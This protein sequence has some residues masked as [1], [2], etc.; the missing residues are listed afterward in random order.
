MDTAFAIERGVHGRQA[1]ELRNLAQRGV[2]RLVSDPA[3]A[4]LGPGQRLLLMS[5]VAFDLS[6]M[7]IWSALL[8]GATVVVAP[9][10]R[11]GL[12]D[13]ASLLRTT[14]V[15]VVWLTAG[16]FHQVAETDI[17]ALA[18]VPVLMSGGDVLNPDAVRAVLAARRGRPFVAG[19]GPAENTTFTS[20]HVMTDP[21]QVAATVPIG[22]PIQ[23]T[24]VR[25]LDAR[26]LPVPIGVTGELCT[27]GDGLA[28]G[29]A[30]DAAATARAAVSRPFYSLDT[31]W[32]AGVSWD[33][34]D[35]ID[36][37]Y[38]A[39][40][41][42]AQYRHR[43]KIAEAYAGWSPG[44]VH[45]LAQRFSAGVAMQDDTYAVEPGDVAA[46]LRTHPGVQESVVLV[47]GEGEQ[48]HLIGYVTPADGVDPTALRP[49]MLHDFA[50]QRLPDYLV[51][52]AFKA[53][54]RFPLTAN[55]KVDRAALPPP[56]SQARG[57]AA[58]PR[59]ATEER[60]AEI[61]RLLL[62]QHSSRDIGRDD[63]FFALG[64]N[65][66]SAARLM[67][68][69]GEV[70]GVDLGLAAFYEAPTLAACAA[71]IDAARPAAQAA[72]GA[73]APAVAPPSTGRTDREAAPRQP[74][75]R[76]PVSAP[77][78]A[79]GR[80]AAPAPHPAQDRPATLGPHLVRL[81]DDW[82]LWRAVCLRGAGFGVHLLEALGDAELARAADAVIAA[83]AAADREAREAAGAGYA[84]EF[85]AA[86]RRLSAALHEVA[87]L[88]AL[89]EA[90]AWQN[91]HA[92]TTGIDVLVRRGPEP[93][94]RNKLHRQHEA[95]VASYL[96]RYCAKNDSIGFFGPMSWAQIDDGR[97]IRIDH[98]APG[99]PLAARIT[100]LEGWAVRAIMADHA[101]ASVHAPSQR[102]SASSL[103]GVS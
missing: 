59:G 65:S 6:T 10:G 79:P 36:S 44:L 80:P 29:Y 89:R 82:S 23:H 93:A 7:E 56:E 8:T 47:A 58:P 3:Y 31:R 51:P 97:G 12:P 63:T 55:G 86:V 18:T 75:D 43:W 72:A 88:P 26:G 1:E 28:R 98:A 95:L 2:I 50:A 27:G 81:T 24:T 92:L 54:A 83:D 66:L 84:A 17:G 39:G 38:N 73:P 100:Y 91:R 16:L 20:C 13:V 68:R 11:L 21:S 96:Q 40:D 60:L 22:R 48:R 52:T 69:I 41:V 62:P 90:V 5:P 32:A 34:W 101:T 33:D 77:H 67:F 64:G 87:G 61:W 57:E 99:L 53:V 78:P 71:A 37:I 35:R 15:T 102:G 103:S 4:P 76:L 45:G 94:K 19:Y 74:Q 25:V 70:F 85:P 46:V 9:P 42:I 14:G 49:S 30:G